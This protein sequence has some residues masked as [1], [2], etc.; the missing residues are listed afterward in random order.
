M[1]TN[2]CRFLREVRRG[3]KAASELVSRVKLTSYIF[4][5]HY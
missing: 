4:V 3:Q 1:T 2:L 5:L